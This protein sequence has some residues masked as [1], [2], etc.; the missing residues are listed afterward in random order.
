MAAGS[1][2]TLDMRRPVPSKKFKRVPHRDYPYVFVIYGAMTSIVTRLI[3]PYV[4][5][6]CGNGTDPG[7]FT[8]IS[9]ELWRQ[10]MAPHFPSPVTWTLA[11]TNGEALAAVRSGAADMFVGG[12]TVTAQ[13]MLNTTWLKTDLDGSLGLLTNGAT[14]GGGVASGAGALSNPWTYAG[15]ALVAVV[16]LTLGLVTWLVDRATPDDVALTWPSDMKRGVPQAA[17][18]ALNTLTGN[19]AAYVPVSTP[20]KLWK[21]VLGFGNMVVLGAIAA[22]SALLVTGGPPAYAIASFDDTGGRPIGVGPCENAPAAY[23]RRHYPTAQLVCAESIDHSVRD[24]QDGLVDGVVYDAPYLIYT[25]ATERENLPHAARLLL[26][27]GAVGPY[28]VG[29]ACRPDDTATLHK[30]QAGML[31]AVESGLLGQLETQFMN[32]GVSVTPASPAFDAG[33]SVAGV[34]FWLLVVV[35]LAGGA[36]ALVVFRRLGKASG[37]SGRAILRLFW[38]K[39][40]NDE[41]W[42]TERAKFLTPAQIEMEDGRRAASLVPR[43]AAIPHLLRIV[44]DLRAELA[45]LAE[46]SR[47]SAIEP[48]SAPTEPDSPDDI[49]VEIDHADDGRV[50]D[51]GI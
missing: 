10:G 38:H 28:P 3:P 43:E 6:V 30:M 26:E 11:T 44:G 8:G 36:V 18:G 50:D 12:A 37:R 7:C 22:V 31:D 1:A 4:I 2:G 16:G 13:R 21:F 23:M 25:Q 19:S 35:A 9:I 5:D 47:K 33:G 39:V 32:G 27:G 51:S 48:D 46:L 45:E 14:V 42:R 40:R 41:V 29:F 34:F 15:L 20:S 17:V 49:R 24:L